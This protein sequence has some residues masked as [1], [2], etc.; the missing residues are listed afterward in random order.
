MK[1]LVATIRH[2]YHV[3]IE[4][5]LS[6]LI[7]IVVIQVLWWYWVFYTQTVL[8][9]ELLSAFFSCWILW[10][11][12]VVAVLDPL[13]APDNA[14][15]VRWCDHVWLCV[16]FYTSVDLHCVLE[17][18]IGLR[19]LLFY[20]L[21]IVYILFVDEVSSYIVNQL[22]VVDWFGLAP[23]LLCLFFWVPLNVHFI[24]F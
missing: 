16:S 20:Q 11:Q 1:D 19:V 22:D 10:N 12:V 21:T 15:F 24:W 18:R 6:Y 13:R 5:V 2:Y 7:S 4:K 3:L 14:C 17:L 9:H 8:W 23:E